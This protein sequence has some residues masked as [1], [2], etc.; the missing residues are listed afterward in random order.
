MAVLKAKTEGLDK[1]ICLRDPSSDYY[2]NLKA[3]AMDI[4][5]FYQCHQCKEPYFGGK[6]ECGAGEEF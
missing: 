3:Y 4:L 5:A 2:N 6:K 1:N